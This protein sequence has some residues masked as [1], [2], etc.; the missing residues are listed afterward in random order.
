MS[1]ELRDIRLIG[2]RHG[3]RLDR[4]HP[5]WSLKTDFEKI[6]YRYHWNMPFSLPVSRKLT[7]FEQDTYFFD[8]GAI[9][10]RYIQYGL[11]TMEKYFPLVRKLIPKKIIGAL[12]MDI[13]DS[14][15]SHSDLYGL[16]KTP[17]PYRPKHLKFRMG[18]V[19]ETK[20]FG[21]KGVVIGW[22]LTALAPSDWFEAND[23]DNYHKDSKM[24]FYAVAIT[25][26][27]LSLPTVFYVAQAD[28]LQTTGDI[29][30]PLTKKF[31]QSF[32]K[33]SKYKLRPVHQ[34]TYPYD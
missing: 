21:Y 30:H 17:R 23:P 12:D 24:P 10:T 3:E 6:N 11:K 34:T 22:D 13:A 7:E 8:I 15:L 20:N 14:A 28:L 4:L 27:Q 25:T 19:V 29:V 32:D 16:S 5:D 1:P 18:D 33:Y 26:R 9:E 2:I 31:F